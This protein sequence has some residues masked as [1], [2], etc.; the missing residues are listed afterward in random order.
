[1]MA[2]EDSE[3]TGPA[4]ILVKDNRIAEIERSVERPPGARVLDLPP[5]GR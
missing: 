1:M 5:S 3:M 4:E 2:Q